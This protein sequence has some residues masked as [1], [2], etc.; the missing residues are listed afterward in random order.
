MSQ[1]QRKVKSGLHFFRSAAEKWNED[2]VS[3]MSGS[4]AY[5][6]V[7]SI[8]PLLIIVI[9]ISGFIFGVQASQ[10]QIFTAIQ[11]LVGTDG[12]R[13]IQAIVRNSAQK[14]HAGLFATFL[15]LLTLL[16]G[17]SNAF[18]QLQQ[19]LNTIWRVRI[20]PTY[21]IWAMIRQRLLSFSMILV[22][23]F[24]LLVSLILTAVISALGEFLGSKLPGG[25]A[26]WHGLNSGVSFLIATL[27]FAAIYKILPDVKLR[28][29]DVW[30]GALVT[31]VLFT[32]GKFLIGVYL[33][34][35]SI[36]STYGAF[37]S[38]VVILVWVY[39]SSAILFY[40]AEFTWVYAT[41]EGR[42]IE[43]VE[44]AELIQIQKLTRN[45]KNKKE[46]NY[47]FESRVS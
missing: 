29:K 15:S 39:F 8:A 2:N 46:A 42:L 31:S 28:W 16:I 36:T 20:K 30:M 34:H 32:L 3:M 38:L 44:G 1:V 24:L 41:R 22:I 5:S 35:S 6:T 23:A 13:A 4:L 21:G 11:K 14:P 47:T 33:G 17:A 25:E 9:A 19:S 26:F 27:L 10:G 18:Q 12:A 40:G 37:G 7:F 43:P 45:P